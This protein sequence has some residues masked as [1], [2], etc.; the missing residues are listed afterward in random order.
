M[1]LVP[2]VS[3]SGDL[4]FYWVDPHGVVRNLNKKDSPNVWVMA[5]SKG[6]GNT[7]TE[8]DDSKLPRSPGTLINQINVGAREMTLPIVVVQE[9]LGDLL[10]AVE[11]ISGWFDTGEETEKRPGHLRI[12][13]PDGSYRQILCYA[14][15]GMEGDTEEGSPI[16][17]IYQQG[18]YAPDPIP[19]ALENQVVNKT[20]TEGFGGGSGFG[21]INA[22]T[23]NAYPIWTLTGPFSGCAI[24]NLDTDEYIQINIV[25][26]AGST[27]VVDTRPSES[28]PGLQIYDETGTS[29]IN[30]IAPL[31]KFWQLAPGLNQIIINFTGGGTNAATTIK[32][33]YLERFRTLLR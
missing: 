31:S 2:P 11:T 15:D 10:L 18:L 14:T 33:E 19:T 13:W 24:Y 16:Y 29:H 7:T 27:L 3:V 12:K 8:I 25:F 22:G 20:V 28:R 17:T 21:V 5:G 26:P 1:R 23:R 9:T 4:E 32:L 6:L 30:T